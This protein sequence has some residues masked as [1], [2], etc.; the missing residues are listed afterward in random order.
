MQFSEKF[1]AES[2]EQKETKEVRENRLAKVIQAITNEKFNNGRDAANKIILSEETHIAIATFREEFVI[3]QPKIINNGMRFP[4]KILQEV[5]EAYSQAAVQQWHYSYK[6]CGLLEDAVLSLVLHYVPANDAQRFAQGLH[7]LQDRREKFKRLCTT[8]DGCPFYLT[9]LKP[10]F[11][12]PLPSACVDIVFGQ[13]SGE[14]VAGARRGS[15][16]GRCKTYVEKKL[17][18]CRTFAA[19]IAVENT[20]VR[21]LLR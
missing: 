17:Q 8:R 6:K 21:T 18:I 19:R 12:F 13:G 9:L 10:S 3:S 14:R 1:G 15:A 16:A 20:S 4:L 11:D 2:D 7:F 5:C